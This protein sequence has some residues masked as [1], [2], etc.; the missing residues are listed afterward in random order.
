MPSSQQ[1]LIAF[2]AQC[3][4]ESL[5]GE[6]SSAPTY[7]RVFEGDHLAGPLAVALRDGLVSPIGDAP[8]VLL[9]S[10]RQQL[11]NPPAEDDNAKRLEQAEGRGPDSKTQP[12]GDIHDAF[13]ADWS[14][15]KLVSFHQYLADM[16]AA[17]PEVQTL[18]YRE[19][20]HNM[21]HVVSEI[22]RR[23]PSSI[24]AETTL[25]LE[26]LL[27][28]YDELSGSAVNTHV[29]SLLIPAGRFAD[30]AQL[31]SAVATNTSGFQAVNALSN[32]AQA[33]LLC[34]M[35][36]KAEALLLAVES[37]GNPWI[38]GEAAYWLGHIYLASGNERQGQDSLEN[39]L[40][41]DELKSGDSTYAEKV[42]GCIAGNC[43]EPDLDVSPYPT[44][45]AKSASRT[46]LPLETL[47][48]LDQAMSIVR[49]LFGLPGGA[50]I[51][52]ELVPSVERWIASDWI[53]LLG[54]LE[55]TWG[56]DWTST[57]PEL[58]VASALLAR[59]DPGRRLGG[60]E[61][62]ARHVGFE[63]ESQPVNAQRLFAHLVDAC[64]SFNLERACAFGIA[65]LE[66]PQN[67]DSEHAKAFR[68]R[69]ITLVLEA[70]VRSR[71][72]NLVDEWLANYTGAES[73]NEWL[74]WSALGHS[75]CGRVEETFS[76][77]DKCTSED[78]LTQSVAIVREVSRG[79]EWDELRVR[80]DSVV[81]AASKI[82]YRSETGKSLIR[83]T[84]KNL[85]G[86]ANWSSS[87]LGALALGMFEFYDNRPTAGVRYWISASGAFGGIEEVKVL[88]RSLIEGN[89]IDVYE[90]FETNSAYVAGSTIGILHKHF[91]FDCVIGLSKTHGLGQL[92]LDGEDEAVEFVAK[93]LV[94]NPSEELM[95]WP[96]DVEALFALTI[97][98][99]DERQAG[100]Y[101]QHE[102]LD[103]RL[104]VAESGSIS[105]SIV[106]GVLKATTTAEQNQT[107]MT[108]LQN[109]SLSPAMVGEVSELLDADALWKI[110]SQETM[111]PNLLG[112]WSKHELPSVRRAVAANPATP[113]EILEELALDSSLSVRDAVLSN[114]VATDEIRALV[115]LQG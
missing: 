34:G 78:I 83:G 25:A 98:R 26:T 18:E 64:G 44:S 10:A 8:F 84:L 68:S 111:P 39:A 3:Y 52:L 102:R 61:F 13:A 95:S 11:L 31:L 76:Q 69:V 113:P 35:P 49:E 4:E 38:A 2:V 32:L 43:A 33:Y 21:L 16:V 27:E 14:A 75:L 108:L 29:F 88:R 92:Y 90:L 15:G 71:K 50:E 53:E 46:S 82:V 109:P 80:W 115:S 101:A 103:V 1:E 89:E 99:A 81:E 70:L 112:A 51:D 7:R 110:A 24:P 77:L 37:S 42:R 114:P 91:P 74:L 45:W 22:D 107:A 59:S 62:L 106:R 104:M 58:T 96:F 94:N 36:I 55:S 30:A 56:Q 67:I 66:G 57:D 85:P 9:E 19:Q 100:L 41:A 72:E 105:D 63:A 40:F 93:Y 87:P 23:D 79:L 47:P 17:K 6:T 12:Y 65:L 86:P 60:G 48:D 20:L 54:G 73:D 97:G 28:I 5:A